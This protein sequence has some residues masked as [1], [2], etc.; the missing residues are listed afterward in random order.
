MK[1]TNAIIK[2]LLV[3]MMGVAS[4]AYAVTPANTTITNTAQLNYT[5]LSSPL[6]ASVEVTI[7]LTPAAPTLSSSTGFPPPDQT[8]PENQPVSY[9]YTI[10]ANANGSDVYDL[11]SDPFGIVNLASTSVNA[12]FTQGVTTVTQV[13][14]GATAAS[15]IAGIGVPTISVPSDG[16]ANASVNGLV[17]NDTV[18]IGGNVYTI[19]SIS[20]NGITA[21]ITLTS[22]LTTAVAVGDLIAEQQTFTATIPDVGTVN[23]TGSVANVTMVITA[24]SVADP[25][26]TT[27]DETFTTVVEVTFTKY[28]RN[29][30]TPNGS[31]G[32]TIINGDPFFTTAGNVS[33]ES[34]ETLEYA[35]VVTAPSTPLNGVS[36]IDTI[37]AFTSYVTGTTTLNGSAVAD[38]AGPVSP[39]IGGMAV[40][41]SGSGAGTVAANQT[42]T[43][44]FQVL[45]E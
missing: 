25:L 21:S 35:L 27:S 32:S 7:A 42:A 33:A 28:V 20:D 26:E 11:D 17:A 10:T 12:V 18:V 15:A 39:L 37:P 19:L 34:G 30:D 13:T 23:P 29:V 38:D 6:S 45:V 9:I 31:G 14:L 2:T 1:L 3:G 22:N 44:T 40:N 5:G 24:T 8:V 43:V 36:L 4:I 16:T 41:D